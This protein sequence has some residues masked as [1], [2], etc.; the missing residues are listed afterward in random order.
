VQTAQ[1]DTKSTSL[2]YERFAGKVMLHNED[3]FS[4]ILVDR[5][6]SCLVVKSYRAPLPFELPD[7]FSVT[8]IIITPQM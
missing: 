7:T 2:P 3:N 5:K 1:H 6:R 4:E 8:K